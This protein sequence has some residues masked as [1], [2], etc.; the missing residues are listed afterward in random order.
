MLKFLK[1]LEIPDFTTDK[2]YLNTLIREELQ[3][4]LSKTK[5][6][7]VLLVTELDNEK[8]DFISSLSLP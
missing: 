8:M 3:K 1:V 7:S 2:D 6:T 4:R 5:V